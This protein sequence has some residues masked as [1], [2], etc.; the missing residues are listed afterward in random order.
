MQN[1]ELQVWTLFEKMLNDA[2][3][4]ART[5]KDYAKDMKDFSAKVQWRFGPVKGYQIF[6]GTEYSY[7][8]DGEIENPDITITDYLNDTIVQTG[9]SI[10][11][12]RF[13]RFVLGEEA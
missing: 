3:E 9:E 12:R 2:A 11:I 6:K 5:Y 4:Y 10:T 1:K 7:Q 13:A 8:S